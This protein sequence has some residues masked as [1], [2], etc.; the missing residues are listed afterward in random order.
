MIQ[1]SL[2]ECIIIGIVTIFCALII[3]K[4]INLFGSDEIKYTNF[5]SKYK[6]YILFYVLL[7]IIGILIHIFVKYAQINE[8]Y[9]KKVCDNKSCEILCHLPINGFTN[10]LITN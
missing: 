2:F 6:K 10:L 3:E 7:F 5:F 4:I 1:I 9:C 8:W